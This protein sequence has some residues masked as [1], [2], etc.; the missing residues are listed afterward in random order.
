MALID[1]HVCSIPPIMVFGLIVL[2]LVPKNENTTLIVGRDKLLNK[3]SAANHI[4][5]EHLQNESGRVI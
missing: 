5:Y 3:S 2:C 1:V 4:R